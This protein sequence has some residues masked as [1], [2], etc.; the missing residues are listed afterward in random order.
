LS[1][2]RWGFESLRGYINIKVKISIRELRTLIKELFETK[3]EPDT[4]P[5]EKGD[6]VFFG[7]Y[8]NK[9][10]KIVDTYLDDKDHVAIEIEPSPKGRKKNVE[11]GLYKVWP[12]EDSEDD[13]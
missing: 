1:L 8:K 12:N 7:K 10:G 11:M 4:G 5:F 6:D 2:R 13:K 9:K 3:A